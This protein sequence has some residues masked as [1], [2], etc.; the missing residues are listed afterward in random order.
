MRFSTIPT[1]LL[2]ASLAAACGEPRKSPAGLRLPDGN[3]VAGERAFVDLKCHS[4]HRVDGVVLPAPVAD[5][6]VDVL[7][8]GDV[9]R[10]RTDGELITAIINPSHR[11]APGYPIEQVRL[12]DRSRMGDYGYAMTVQQL[13]DLVAFLHERYRVIQPPP[14]IM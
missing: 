7:L 10:P 8:G 4:C 5:P 14:P 1:V 12:G 2:V 11:L 6:G 9:M 3:A 13:V